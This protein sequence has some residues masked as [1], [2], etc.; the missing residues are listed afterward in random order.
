MKTRKKIPDFPRAVF[1]YP[2]CSLSFFTPPPKN[3]EYCYISTFFTSP[4][5]FPT[6]LCHWVLLSSERE[7]EQAR[8]L[9]TAYS[10]VVGQKSSR[11]STCIT[12]C[13][14]E[15]IVLTDFPK[16]QQSLVAELHVRRVTTSTTTTTQVTHSQDSH[17]AS[18]KTCYQTLC[19]GDM[20]TSSFS[21]PRKS[22][23]RFSHCYCSR[24][25]SN[26]IRQNL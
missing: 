1:H 10:V 11:P 19:V 12:S 5:A 24:S 25:H 13:R 14:G 23:R 20:E 15:A 2:H 21:S 26:S 22:E 3:A 17:K 18:P 6:P 9:R 16:L 8:E 7:N 4:F